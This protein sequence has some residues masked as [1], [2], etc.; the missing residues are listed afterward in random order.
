MRRWIVRFLLL[1]LVFFVAACG[2]FWV[3]HAR[4]YAFP[5]SSPPSRDRAKAHFEQRGFGPCAAELR[6]NREFIG[7]IG[8]SVPNF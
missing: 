5:R 1:L 7:F 3:E 2:T 6:R 8:L 4:I